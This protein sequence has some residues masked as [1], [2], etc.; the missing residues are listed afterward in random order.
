MAC[1]YPTREAQKIGFTEGNGR[2]LY[3]IQLEADDL[4]DTVRWVNRTFE[5]CAPRAGRLKPG[6][7]RQPTP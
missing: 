5:N 1:L 4:D 6:A 3:G 2:Y 7:Q